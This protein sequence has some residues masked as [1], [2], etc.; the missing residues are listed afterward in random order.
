M[1][2][3]AGQAVLVEV[4]LVEEGVER[5]WDCYSHERLQ[6]KRLAELEHA[7][8]TDE[9]KRNPPIEIDETNFEDLWEMLFFGLVQLI[10]II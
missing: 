8:I 1:L 5:V 10:F 7:R 6:R 4:E 3:D 9:P 2:V